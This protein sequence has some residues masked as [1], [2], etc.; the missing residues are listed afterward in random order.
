MHI[1]ISTFGTQ[2]DIQPFIALGKELRAAGYTVAVCTA[3]SYR[4]LVEAHGL[5]YAFMNDTL[6]DL[7]RAIMEQRGETLSLMRRMSPAMRGTMEDEWRAAQAFEP[8]AIVYHPKMLGSYH[9]A[10]KLDIPLIM[11]IPLPFYTPTRAFPNPFLANA[12]LGGWFNRFSYQLMGLSSLIFAGMINAF[13]TRTLGLTPQ[14]HFA[15]PLITAQGAPIPVLYPYSPALLSVPADFPGHVH[16]TGYWFLEQARDWQPP[17]A[18]VRFL[19][20]GPPP[21]YIGFGS[22]IGKQAARRAQIVLEALAKSGQRGVLARGWGGLQ[23]ADLP[24]TV[25][26]LDEA[27]HDWLFPRMAA[28]VHHGGAGTTAAGLRAGK[29]TVICPFLGDQ[30]FWGRLVYE[31]G[32]GPQ[33]IPQRKLTVERLAAAITQAISDDEMRR[34]AIELGQHIRAEDGVGNAV[35]IVST[36]AK[37]QRYEAAT[38]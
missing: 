8:D 3:E 1:L 7:S 22:M 34:R 38:G 9:I 26:M 19:E 12:R 6:L 18:L 2:G 14:G 25:Y 15:D 28:V 37:L 23:P 32:V 13:R 24:A 4:P 20:V 11:A 33:P 16:V 27:P 35:A 5:R 31:R 21:V 36:N 29:P 30:L 10:E 17:A